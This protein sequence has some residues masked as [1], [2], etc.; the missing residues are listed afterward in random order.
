MPLRSMR[1]PGAS[2]RNRC[3]PRM[4]NVSTDI[5]IRLT[6]IDGGDRRVPAIFVALRRRRCLLSH[7]LADGM[8]E[9]DG[10]RFGHQTVPDGQHA[11]RGRDGIGTVR[12]NDPG[13][14]EC[15]DGGVHPSL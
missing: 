9:I 5:R 14:P 12:D 10:D 8:T 7:I 6:D 15:L 13:Q 11:G 4:K 3:H 1:S 2:I